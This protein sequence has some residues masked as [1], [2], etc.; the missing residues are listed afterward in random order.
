MKK[1]FLIVYQVFSALL[2]TN[3][4]SGNF[5]FPGCFIATSIISR[6]GQFY[7]QLDSL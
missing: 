7:K 2:K 5:H 6:E 4:F 3:F 1:E